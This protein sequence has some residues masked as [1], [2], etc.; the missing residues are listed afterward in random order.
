MLVWIFR[1]AYSLRNSEKHLSHNIPVDEFEKAKKALRKLIQKEYF[2]GI[3]DLYLRAL[4]RIKD[5]AGLFR[6]KTN[7]VQCKEKENIRYPIR[8][9][10]I[11]QLNKYLFIKKRVENQH[12][13]GT[14]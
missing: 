9:R 5:K 11:V 4:R 2:T 13:N 12:I 10:P 8:Y 14:S 3:R 6:V 1:Y 7:I